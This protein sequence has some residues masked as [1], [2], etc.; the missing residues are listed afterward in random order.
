MKIRIFVMTMVILLISACSKD[1]LSSTSTLKGIIKNE[2]GEPIS[3]VTIK[4][5]LLTTSSSTDGS[6]SIT[7]IPEGDYTLTIN[8]L[9]YKDYSS[10][11]S[12]TKPV[13]R[14]VDLTMIVPGWID[15]YFTG[16]YAV[17]FTVNGA[18]VGFADE[19]SDMD[20]DGT[21]VFTPNVALG[22]LD[23]GPNTLK[24]IG[25]VPTSAYTS[26]TK[27]YA[28][29]VYAVKTLEGNYVIFKITQMTSQSRMITFD[30]KYQAN[31]GPQF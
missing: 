29:N 24:N 3:G 15:T 19:Q 14:T 25:T 5:N 27:A 8:K 21:N 10:Q 17:N 26:S 18:S 22:I 28:G 4:C 9:G 6:Y 12:F 30:W 11:N 16:D 2:A 31:G 7:G 13:I 23:L 1:D 20:Y